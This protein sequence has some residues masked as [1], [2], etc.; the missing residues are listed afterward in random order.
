MKNNALK[1]LVVDNH[2][3]FLNSISGIL[4]GPGYEVRTANGGLEAI[5]ILETFKPQLFFIDFI[6]PYI[7]GEKLTRYI[8]AQEGYEDAFIVILS[9]IASE[10]DH[11]TIPEGADA[12]IAKGPI[13]HMAGHIHDVI[14]QYRN[15]KRETP[16][17]NMLGLTEIIPR[18]ITKELLFSL[19]HL[20]VLLDN[21]KEGVVE[22]AIDNRIVYINPAAIRILGSDEIGLLSKDFL[23]IIADEDKERIG[24]ILADFD[25]DLQVK[26]F[27]SRINNHFV[28]INIL[29]V[30]EGDVQSKIILIKDVTSFKEKEDK[31]NKALAEK[32]ML[33]KEIHHRVKNNLNI[34]SGLI[35]IQSSMIKDET[36]RNMLLEIQPRL[37]SI[38][39]VH[40]KLYHSKDL[41]NISLRKYL[42]E[43]ASLLINMMSDENFAIRLEV[44]IPDISLDTEMIVA[45]GL[46]STELITNAV[47]YGFDKDNP[48]NVLKIYLEKHETYELTISNNGNKIPVG[49]DVKESRKL[50]F[51]VIELLIKQMGARLESN[52]DEDTKFTIIFQKLYKSGP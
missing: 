11:I 16:S 45:I 20:E 48:D 2:L 39:L 17:V 4:S 51:Q 32:E 33:I 29:G 5:D 34:I 12:F 44:D 47:K 35:S 3:L 43:L 50:G 22:V 21:M 46:I 49:F 10:T 7:N 19:R 15:I 40:D 38:S 28:Q 42:T 13:K 37:Q 36:L 1:I 6:M 30:T 27:L 14:N 25:S 41:V 31:I 18:H 24:N 23:S 52:F 9:G 8:R 26:D